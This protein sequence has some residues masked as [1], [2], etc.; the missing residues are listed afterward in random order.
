VDTKPRATWAD[1]SGGVDEWEALMHPLPERTLYPS[2]LSLLGNLA[3]MGGGTAVGLWAA[4]S[5]GG[6]HWAWPVLG[7]VATAVV[8]V[9]LLPGAAF[10]RL[11]PEGLVL[12][13][14]FRTFSYRWRDVEGFA[15][16]S[17]SLNKMVVYNH[18]PDAPVS[19]TA[20]RVAAAMSG[21]EAALPD[22]FGL[23]AEEL[24]DLLNEYKRA[25]ALAALE[26]RPQALEKGGN[27]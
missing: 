12:R 15:A 22:T 16:A 19:L 1:S 3:L 20:R 14:S 13:Y 6:L 17:I 25:A 11:G 18:A 9:Q 8:L 4:L 7:G 27:P 21:W 10:L 2:R 5:L 26:E 23:T 24:A